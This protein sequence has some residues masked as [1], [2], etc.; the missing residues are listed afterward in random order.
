VSG[1]VRRSSHGSIAGVGKLR[2]AYR[3][4][5]ASAPRAALVIIH[6]LGDHSGRYD[7]FAAR[8][9]VVGIS[10]YAMDLRGHGNSEGRR[11]H[12]P[13]FDVFLQ[14]VDR[15]RREV[16]GLAGHNIPIFLLGQSMGGLIALR[17]M[18]EYSGAFRGAVICSPW[19]ATAM[20][21]PRW[22]S[23]V[24]PLMARLAPAL[25]FRHGLDPALLSRDPVV[26]DAYRNDSLVQPIIT[27]RTFSEVSHAM[28]EALQRSDRIRAPLLFLMGDADGIVDTNRT[29]SFARSLAAPDITIRVVPGG[30]HELL[31]EI[32][33][34][35]TYRVIRDWIMARV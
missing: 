6:G 23:I 19:L 28:G 8:M 15:F 7:D 1:G 30:Y 18:E 10:A 4:H 27:P 9:A 14:E 31:L 20:R 21:V 17:Y 25:P 12:V 33:R 22:K 3:A 34:I 16:E 32:D 2:L 5:E 35:A 26:A 29:L 11:G 24:A 13:S